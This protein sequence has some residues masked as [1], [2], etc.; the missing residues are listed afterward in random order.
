MLREM[1]ESSQKELE[2][3]AEKHQEQLQDMASLQEKL[4]VS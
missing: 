3:L 2:A 4:K 1:C